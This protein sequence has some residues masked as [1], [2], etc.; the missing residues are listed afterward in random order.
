MDKCLRCTIYGLVVLAI[1]LGALVAPSLSQGQWPGSGPHMPR[2]VVLKLAAGQE[3]TPI[4]VSYSAHL[5]RHWPGQ[6]IY[7]I[8]LDGMDVD[9]LQVVAQMQADPRI[10]W[11]EPNFISKVPEADPYE[12]GAWGGYDPTPYHQQYAATAINLKWVQEMWRGAGVTV[13]ILDTG[14]QLDH[15]VLAPH[16]APDSWDFVDED[17]LPAEEANGW[18][19]DGDGYVDSAFGHGTHVAGIVNLVAP[20]AQLLILRVLDDEG[21]GNLFDVSQA[22]I[23]AV[24]HGAQV[25]N[26]SMG[27][28]DTSYV[29][30]TALDYATAFGV[31]VVAAAGNL[32]STV[33]Q[34]PAALP[35]VIGV[36]ALDENRQKASFSSYGEWVDIAAPGVGIYSTY[37]VSGYGWWSGTSMATPFVAGQVAL[38]RQA[39]P[40]LFRSQVMSQVLDTALNVDALNPDYAGLLGSGELDALR[41]VGCYWADVAPDAVHSITD[42]TCDYQV[43][44]RDIQAV[45]SAWGQNVTDARDVDNDRDVD[46]ADVMAVSRRWGWTP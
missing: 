17:A 42:H 13:A 29:L 6:Q 37:P 36:A 28:A 41:S 1:L 38:V 35:D 23:Y 30:Q 24:D 25:I 14:V 15:P 27:A 40:E 12:I 16:L 46:I 3:L 44:L 10:E 45:A 34:Y 4:L 21:R 7:L 11:A 33:P 43:D 22:I 32:D 39:A 19:D 5:L 2:H 9:V 8:Y 31:V 18:D 20:E 26:M